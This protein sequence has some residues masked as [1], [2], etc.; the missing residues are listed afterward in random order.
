MTGGI[1]KGR[2]MKG[3]WIRWEGSTLLTVSTTLCLQRTRSA[4]ALCS[5][6]C[7]NVLIEKH[8]YCVFA[9]VQCYQENRTSEGTNMGSIKQSL[10][11]IKIFRF[12]LFLLL[13]F[14]PDNL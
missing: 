12:D 9:L 1:G 10:E 2:W 13:L 6:Q 14:H 11:G 3:G 5:D 7:Y 8:R 4:H